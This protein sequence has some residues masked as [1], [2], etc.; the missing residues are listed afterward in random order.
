MQNEAL[1]VEGDFSQAAGVKCLVDV[2]IDLWRVGGD[3]R[4]A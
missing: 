4:G 2:A 1:A 3:H